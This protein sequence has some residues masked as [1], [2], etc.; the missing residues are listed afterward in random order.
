MATVAIGPEGAATVVLN[1]QGGG[2]LKVGPIG[3]R[4]VWSP[5]VASVSAT[6]GSPIV[7]EAQCRIYIGPSPTP[8][9]FVDGTL[10]GS[11]G[12]STANVSGSSVSLPWSVWAVW[13]GGDPGAVATLNVSGTKAI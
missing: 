13:S 8:Q 1:G 11:T 10:S 2:T 7:N 12:D 9:Y 6:T 4:E 3:P 5:L